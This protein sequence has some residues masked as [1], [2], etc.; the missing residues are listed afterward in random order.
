MY[1]RILT[2]QYVLLPGYWQG[3]RARLHG[4]PREFNPWLDNNAEQ[5]AW[6]VGWDAL[7]EE[8]R[9]LQQLF[10]D[11]LGVRDAFWDGRAARIGEKPREFNPYP[12]QTAEQLAW[13]R[14]WDDEV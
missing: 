10:P 13:W 2:N 7:E 11:D 9:R 3:C 5:L 14:G 1:T 8:G 12:D 6:W 4:V